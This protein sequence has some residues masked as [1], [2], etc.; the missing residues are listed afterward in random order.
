MATLGNMNSEVRKTLKYFYIQMLLKVYSI[1][2]KFVIWLPGAKLV[3]SNFL[4]KKIEIFTSI[5]IKE[6]E[7]FFHTPNWITEYRVRTLYSKEPET[8]EWINKFTIGSVIFDIGAN[9]GMYSIYAAVEKNCKVFAFEV[10]PPNLES[11]YRNVA[12]NNI[13]N[14]SVV[15]I[16]LSS[17]TKPTNLFLSNENFTWGGAHNSISINI[18][19]KGFTMKNTLDVSTIGISL[20]DAVKYLKLPQPKYIKIDVDGLEFLILKG[21]INTLKKCKSLLIEVDLQN[22][23]SLIL[24]SDFLRKLKFREISVTGEN[25]IWEK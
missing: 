23:K 18:D 10:S 14:V 24:I 8:I 3:F 9:V 4:R 12:K 16:G 7:I 17:Q 5:L 19:Q 21:A 25:Q 11:L 1:L 6:R 13:R 22:S 15:P 20:D 2:F